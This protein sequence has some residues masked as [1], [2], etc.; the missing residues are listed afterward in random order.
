[1]EAETGGRS[2]KLEGRVTSQGGRRPL[3]AGKG[4]ERIFL[5]SFQKVQTPRF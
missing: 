3:G 1:M 2:V 4:Q 5:W